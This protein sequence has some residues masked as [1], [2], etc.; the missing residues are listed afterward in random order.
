MLK[1]S[2]KKMRKKKIQEEEKKALIT[3]IIMRVIESVCVCV[4]KLCA[5]V[6]TPYTCV[7]LYEYE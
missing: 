2:Q 5:A 7:R 4:V 6:R 3:N 1:L